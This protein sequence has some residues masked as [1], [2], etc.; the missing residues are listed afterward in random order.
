MQTVALHLN[1]IYLCHMEKTLKYSQTLIDNLVNKFVDE[2]FDEL[3]NRQRE[4]G[5]AFHGG[6]VSDKMHPA[7]IKALTSKTKKEFEGAITFVM[8][9]SWVASST[10]KSREVQAVLRIAENA[11]IG[12][13]VALDIIKKHT[14]ILD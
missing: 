3:Y 5:D 10:L 7:I 9:Q 4:I 1:I 12:K 11:V 14:N 13:E 6:R 8:F 2:I